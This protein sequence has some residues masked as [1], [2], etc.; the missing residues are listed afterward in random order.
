MNFWLLMYPGELCCDWTMGTI[1]LISSVGDPRNLMTIATYAL[2]VWLTWVALNCECRRKAGVIMMSL[3][4]M[5]LPFVPASNLFFPV[6]FVV[7]ERVLYMPSMG[8][9]MLTAY[10]FQNLATRINLKV[11]WS[12]LGLLVLVHGIKTHN[13]NIDW[14]S[15]YS[16]FMSGLKVRF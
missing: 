13:R 8:F 5:V 10:G 12:C 6:G 9:C 3:A 14:E 1:P 2:T 7:A 4:F 16:I 15:E 11:A